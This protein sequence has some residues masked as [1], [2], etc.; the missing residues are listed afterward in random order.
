MKDILKA[1]IN[2]IVE[3]TDVYGRTRIAKIFG[4]TTKKKGIRVIFENDRSDTLTFNYIKNVAIR[5]GLEAEFLAMRAEAEQKEQ[6]IREKA[7]KN[8]EESEKRKEVWIRDEMPKIIAALGQDIYKGLSE[9]EKMDFVNY[10]AE[11]KDNRIAIREVVA[12]YNLRFFINKILPLIKKRIKKKGIR[13]SVKV[14]NLSDSIYIGGLL[15]ISDHNLPYKYNKDENSL[16][17]DKKIT[18]FAMI[19]ETLSFIN[20]IM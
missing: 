11:E 1:N 10:Y 9:Y 14:S 20:I 16:I 19:R 8:L 5:D 17:F 6:N 15:R 13:V 4:L 2:N 7:R 18:P 3:I 12:K